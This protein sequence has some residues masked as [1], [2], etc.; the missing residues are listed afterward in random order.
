MKMITII[1]LLAALAELSSC[2]R[3][4]NDSNIQAIPLVRIVHPTVSKLNDT[5]AASGMI[6]TVDQSELSFQTGGT[7]EQVYVSEGDFVRKGQLLAR[8]NTAE[9][10][11]QLQQSDLKIAQYKRDIGR[12]KALISDSLVTQEQLQNTQTALA[13]SQAQRNAIAYSLSQASIYTSSSGIILKKMV[14]PG[15]YKSSGAVVFTLGSND[16]GQHWVFKINVTDKDRIKLKLKQQTEIGLDALP[17]RTFKGTVYRM[18]DVPDLTTL[19]YD[20]FISFDPGNEPVVYGLSGK[21]VLPQTS[22]ASYTTLPLEALSGIR[23]GSGT[24][25]LVSGRSTVRKQRIGF[26][27]INQDKV[28]LNTALPAGSSVIIAG[29]NKVEP[30]QK[31][32][33][34]NPAL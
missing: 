1:A 15:E 7:V 21:V 11:A 17:G 33:I 18:A 24:I 26:S 25:Y 19:T 28:V 22:A 27:Q 13:T 2:K 12:F 8:L 32:N 34:Y 3:K 6:T 30:G 5:L 10:T 16:E 20:C 29:K 23:A 4:N 14:S 9:L 31:V